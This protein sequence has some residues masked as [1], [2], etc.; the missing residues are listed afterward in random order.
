MQP[1]N[2]LK[3]DSLSDGWCDK[4]HV[5]LHACFQLLSDFVE[6][7]LPK[8]PQINWTIRVDKMNT[9][10]KELQFGTGSLVKL[11]L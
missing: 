5:L 6:K 7:E 4:D 8:Y 11:I 2:I 3:I 10:M 9:V 1:S